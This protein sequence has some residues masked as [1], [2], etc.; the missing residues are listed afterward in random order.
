[1]SALQADV[2]TLDEHLRPLTSALDDPLVAV[3]KRLPGVAVQADA[4]DA[5]LQAAGD[6][7]EA[8]DIGLDLADQVVTMREADEAETTS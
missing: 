1:M 2:R 7:V 6:L 3:A 5:L 8:A 4:A